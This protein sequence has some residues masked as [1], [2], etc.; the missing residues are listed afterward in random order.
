MMPV[1]KT[2]FY[3]RRAAKSIQV[4]K[5]EER[6]RERVMWLLFFFPF[7]ISFN[8][9]DTQTVQAARTDIRKLKQKLY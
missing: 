2:T 1:Y 6:E 3:P 4:A 8:S 5:W 9:L 7:V